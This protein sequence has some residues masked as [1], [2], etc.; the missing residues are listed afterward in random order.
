MK[1]HPVEAVLIGAGQRGAEVYGEY[2]IR[3]PEDVRIIAVAEPDVVRR[4]WF[5]DRHRIP[6][7]NRFPTWEPLLEQP[8]RG[9]AALI[10]TQDHLH[11]APA[12]QA[13][14]SGYDVLLEKPMATRAEDCR[15]LVKTSE[16]TG[17]QLHISHVLRYTPH[18]QKI[19]QILEDETLGQVV[20][21]AHREDVAWWHM[22]H[23]YVRGNWRKTVESSPMILAKCCH[24]FDI[25][26]W[27]L[28]RQCLWL[29]STGGLRHFRPEQAP[30]GA[31]RHCLDG[32]PV[33]DTCPF[34]APFIYIDLL[35]LWRSFAETA[36]GLPKLAATLRARSPRAAKALATLVPPLKPLRNYRGWPRSVVTHDPQP[37]RILEALRTGPY[38]RCVYHCDNDVVDHQV[39]IMQ[40]EGDLA[41]SLTMQGHADL[42][43]RWTRIEGSRGSL[44]AHFGIG[45]SWIELRDH[46]SN[47]QVRYNTGAERGS[48]HGGGDHA[49]MR[50]FLKSVQRGSEGAL[51]TARQAVES[52]LMALAAEES[53]LGGVALAQDAWMP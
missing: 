50:A 4:N 9:Q 2:A 26:L 17:R 40:F 43:G 41:V 36:H 20:T 32:C 11:V 19:R 29:S 38:G 33:S 34:Y 22:A 53:R 5:G 52:H 3:H 45:G 15:L 30:E 7:K 8:A 13:M 31:P 23:S 35:P 42:E 27:L 18:F 14:R 48:G 16:Q 37:Q 46:R 12:L 10:C 1:K 28:G 25:L 47:R 49:L 44:E 24:D 21:V 39:V 51:T 6:A